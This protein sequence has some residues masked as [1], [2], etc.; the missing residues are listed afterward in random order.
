[1]EHVLDAGDRAS[2]ESA[3]RPPHIKYS[4]HRSLLAARALSG[5][6]SGHSRRWPCCASSSADRV[7]REREDANLEESEVVVREGV[8]GMGRGIAGEEG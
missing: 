3:S 2:S 7:A 6:G 8:G 1:V 5:S 4:T